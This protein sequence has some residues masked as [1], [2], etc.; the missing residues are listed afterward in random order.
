MSSVSISPTRFEAANSDEWRDVVAQTVYPLAV[1]AMGSG[2]SGSITQ[3]NLSPSVKVGDVYTDP[4]ALVRTPRLLKEAPT[5]EVLLLIH[6]GGDG[7][8]MQDG[9][10]VRIGVG[11]ATFLDPTSEYRV[12]SERGARQM[13]AVL[14]RRAM[15]GFERSF[16]EF[17]A[18]PISPASTALQ[19]LRSLLAT[20]F[21][22]AQPA[23]VLESDAIAGAVADLARTA[24]AVSVDPVRD[25]RRS[26]ETLNLLAREFIRENLRD[27]SLSPETVAAATRVSVRRLTAA[28]QHQESPASYIRAERLKAARQEL[29]DE[30]G[31]GRSIA[32]IAYGWGFGDT[33]TFTRAFRRHFGERPS[34]IRPR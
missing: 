18:R 34:E 27:P 19:C 26:D 9:R 33:T 2:F 11:G 30:N 29:L 12:Q 25:E 15:H 5:D 13:V 1:Q 3:Q 10:H 22:G 16:N 8:A 28:M 23:T 17:T 7:Q 6:L 21:A 20:T 14:P 4:I 31:R 24:L 32:D